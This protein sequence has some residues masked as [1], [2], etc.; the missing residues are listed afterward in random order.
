MAKILIIDDSL[1]VRNQLGGVLRKAGHEVV[2]AIDGED[3]LEKLV[4]TPDLDLVFTDYFMPGHDGISMLIKAKEKL[5]GFKFPV[6]MLTT[7]TSEKLKATGKQIGVVAWIVKPFIEDKI[8]MAITKVLAAK[9][10]GA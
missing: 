3:G 10:A 8:L 6:F 4:N 9:K 2:E 7:D 1:S 5:G